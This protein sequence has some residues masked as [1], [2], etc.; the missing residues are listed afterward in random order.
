MERGAVFFKGEMSPEAGL[1]YADKY[2]D[3]AA[4]LQ[5]LEI[6]LPPIREKYNQNRSLYSPHHMR[7]VLQ[8]LAKYT[9]TGDVEGARRVFSCPQTVTIA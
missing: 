4:I 1:H 3:I 7:K 6:C 2:R 5:P 8:A 9:F